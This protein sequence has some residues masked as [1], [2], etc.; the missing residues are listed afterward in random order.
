MS[1]RA[2]CD[3]ECECEV[4]EY[5][6]ARRTGDSSVDAWKNTTAHWPLPASVT[7]GM[8]C[9]PLPSMPFMLSCSK[10]TTGPVWRQLECWRRSRAMLVAV[11]SLVVCLVGCG[12]TDGDGTSAADDSIDSGGSGV[13]GDAGTGATDGGGPAGHLV[14]GGA[15]GDGRAGGDGGASGDGGA[16]G[17]DG[18]GGDG[19]AGGVAA[20]GTDLSG[21]AAGESG[22]GGE[23]VCTESNCQ[24]AVCTGAPVRCELRSLE[25]C[26]SDGLC[27]AVSGSFCRPSSLGI[28]CED[29]IPCEAPC[30]MD[31]SG[32]CGH[33]TECFPLLPADC[34]EHR[35]SGCTPA[36]QICVG[37]L[38]ATCAELDEDEC[39]TVMGCSLLSH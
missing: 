2:T 11:S 23:A 19:G 9:A 24:A 16:G 3:S 4:S 22:A 36:E 25:G 28:D 26:G 20:G 31:E 32:A 14:T 34:Y 35:I 21:G 39:T 33:R 17:D 18:A 29:R 38:P 12:G 27:Q 10:T 7:V 37:T 5:P 8:S 30:V 15:G 13:G 6:L 1:F